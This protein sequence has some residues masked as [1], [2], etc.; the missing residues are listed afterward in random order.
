MQKRAPSAVQLVVLA[1]FVLSCL[2]V[3]LFLWTAFGGPTPLQP[4]SYRVTVRFDDALDLG[5]Q[6]DVRIAGVSVGTV[7]S[8]GLAADNEHAIATLAIEDHYAPLPANTRA[9]L[10]TKTLLGE[11]YVELDRGPPGGPSI[12]EGG[13]I[14]LDHV[15]H[16][17]RLDD[18]LRT[19]SPRTRAAFRTWMEDAATATTGRGT[20]LS[21]SIAE[22][23]P[24]FDGFDR[25]FRLLDTQHVAVR[26]LFRNGAVV[27][28]ALSERRGELSSLIR[29]SNRVFE[30]TA[31][32]DRDIRAA[33]VAFPT[34]LGESTRTLDRLRAFALD[35]DPLV[36]QLGPAATELAP[37]VDAFGR[38]AP[39][40]H[41]LFTGLRPV[42]AAAPR[43]FPALQRLFRDH[44][45]PLLRSLTPFL[46][47]LDP[48]L[49]TIGDYKH[50]LTALVA[51]AT[52]TTNGVLPGAL[53][54]QVHYLR[55][56]SNL[57]PDSLAAM[58]RRLTVN[59]T[60]PYTA[61][62][63]YKRVPRSLL[64]FETRQCAGGITASLDPRT[65]ANPAFAVRTGGD[66]VEAQD[67]FNR[68]E[69]FA[70]AGQTNSAT[71]PAP[72]C[73]RQPPFEPIG[74]RGPLTDYLH[75]LERR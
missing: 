3:L 37:T 30:T 35:A 21:Y 55:T 70:F 44:L 31:A 59:R 61:P 36:R 56:L 10:R 34:F 62:L 24:T 33:L 18:I 25:L 58:P 54:K 32:R 4:Q 26:R 67:F 13:S 6:A 38:L 69:R 12:P 53:G 66:P 68:L 60:N 8:V 17:V 43:A 11:T 50:E 64:N 14:P 20:D 47:Q 19:F 22:L 2:G 15:D 52:A 16:T 5:A 29:N 45:P 23:A 1:C 73:R 7:Q 49:T 51:N 75:V 42:I 72:S 28:R 63:A 41:R 46:R 48:I 74:A 65:P 57:G 27:F 71:I 39:T 9:V 40:A